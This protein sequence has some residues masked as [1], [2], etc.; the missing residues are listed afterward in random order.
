[1][2]LPG[3]VWKSDAMSGEP[4]PELHRAPPDAAPTSA[5]SPL[6]AVLVDDSATFLDFLTEELARCP[7]DIRVAGRCRDGSEALQTIR[8]LAPDLVTLDLEMPGMPG[9]EV[10]RRLR[11]RAAGHGPLRDPRVLM[12]SLH[13][14]PSYRAACAELGAGAFVAKEHLLTDLEPALER[15]LSRSPDA[16]APPG[17]SISG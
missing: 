3:T 13:D 4:C 8:R 15:L 5:P 9:L 1:M 17:D 7:W 2:A 14:D 11:S 12:V 10:L 6:K 16:L